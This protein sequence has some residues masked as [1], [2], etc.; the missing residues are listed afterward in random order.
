[1]RLTTVNLWS[2]RTDPSALERFL[3]AV[4]P[5]VVAAQEVGTNVVDVLSGSHPYGTVEGREDVR[6]RALVATKPIEVDEVPMP[7]RP[8]LRTTVDG[9]G[10]IAVHLANPLDGMASVDLRRKQVDTIL[11]E[12]RDMDRV[13]VVGDLNAT[14]LWPAYRR[15]RRELADGVAEWAAAAGARPS[16]TWSKVPHGPA[17]LRID[18]VLTRGMVVTSC[19]VERVLGSDHLAVTVDL[20]PG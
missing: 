10:V 17:L 5:D 15:L 7:A 12:A 1:M 9:V 14:P 4:R 6:G 13:V 11:D 2:G 19:T 16:R 18:H 20:E 3:E 8:G